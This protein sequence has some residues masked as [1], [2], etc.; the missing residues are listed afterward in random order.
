MYHIIELNAT[1]QEANLSHQ[2]R[3]AVISRW[4]GIPL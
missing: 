1:T 4:C 2:H 3:K